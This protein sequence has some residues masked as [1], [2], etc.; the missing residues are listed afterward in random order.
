MRHRL[1]NIGG[2]TGQSSGRKNSRA[3]TR[4]TARK[5]RLQTTGF[6]APLVRK[7]RHLCVQTC[8]GRASERSSHAGAVQ[9]PS[10]DSP[11]P[12]RVP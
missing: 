4:I 7:K 12:S 9:L 2:L 10:L 11:P 8:A 1:Q 5:T 6:P 3:T